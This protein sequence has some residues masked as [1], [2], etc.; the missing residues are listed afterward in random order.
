MDPGGQAAD[1]PDERIVVRAQQPPP[2]RSLRHVTWFHTRAQG[3]SSAVPPDHVR[4][5]PAFVDPRDVLSA[6]VTA[7]T[8][9]V[10][11]STKWHS[12]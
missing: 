4:D 9:R 8:F 1:G 2:L 10:L 6:A 5:Q 12:K 3:L 7:A 11:T